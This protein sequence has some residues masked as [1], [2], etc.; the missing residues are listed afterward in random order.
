MAG[1]KNTCILKFNRCY[2][3]DIPKSYKDSNLYNEHNSALPDSHTNFDAI[4]WFSDNYENI[5]SYDLNS[6]L[7]SLLLNLS[8]SCMLAI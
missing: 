5:S 1:L 4:F 7:P 2:K 3:I 6:V 8:L